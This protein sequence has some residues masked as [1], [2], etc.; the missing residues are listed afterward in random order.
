MSQI[1]RPQGH[2]ALTPSSHTQ[3]TTQVIAFLK[4]AFGGEVVDQ[5]DAPDGTVHH[6]EVL[7][8]DSV[9]MLGTPKPN[10]A[11]QPAQITLYV[12]DADAVT[13]TY[14]RALAAGAKSLSGP[15][16]QPWGYKSACVRDVG[17]NSWT[18]CAILETLS[19][20]E[21]VKRMSAM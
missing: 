14:D 10:D 1:P 8:G 7:I 20:D 19:H 4:T 6:A 2:H 21:I 13:D 9:V 17:G 15:L 18:I 11:P 3:K 12:D 5:Y 16:T